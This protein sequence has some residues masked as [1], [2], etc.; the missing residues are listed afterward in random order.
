MMQR[1]NFLAFGAA[2]AADAA[3]PGTPALAARAPIRITY[4]AAWPS[5]NLTTHIAAA[6]IQ[7]NC[8]ARCN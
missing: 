4:V 6:I 2:A 5:S 7:E 3:W 1:R 8:T